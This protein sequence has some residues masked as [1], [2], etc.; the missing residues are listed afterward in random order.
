VTLL[1]INSGAQLIYQ[2]ADWPDHRHIGISVVQCA[3]TFF[4]FLHRIMQKKAAFQTVKF[5]FRL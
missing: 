3:D 1:N 2:F 5:I 4:F